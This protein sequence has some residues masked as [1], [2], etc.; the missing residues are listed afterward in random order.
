MVYL[1]SSYEVKFATILDEH[2]IEWSR[3]DPVFWVDSNNKTHRYY[4]DF[5]I[6][7]TYFDTKNDYLIKKDADKIK[8]VQ[9]QNSITVIIV[10]YEHINYEFISTYLP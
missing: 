4:P 1:Q 3:P 9:E 6:N 7:N 2:H 5:L 10:P 8:R